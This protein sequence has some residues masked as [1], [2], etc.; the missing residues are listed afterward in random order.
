MSLWTFTC[1]GV[2]CCEESAKGENGEEKDGSGSVVIRRWHCLRN[3]KVEANVDSFA[4][5][6][7]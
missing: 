4:T 6:V 7:D 5:V 2:L 1:G 3:I